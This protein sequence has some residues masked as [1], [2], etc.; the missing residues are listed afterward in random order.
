M[1]LITGTDRGSFKRSCSK[2]D[3]GAG[4]ETAREAPG[5]D[6]ASDL[7]DNVPAVNEDEIDGE[8]HPEGMH[9]LA[10]HD[11]K[12]FA[13]CE[14]L[15]TEEATCAGRSAIGYFDTCHEALCPQVANL[16]PRSRVSSPGLRIARQ[17][18]FPE[19]ARDIHGRWR[20]RPYGARLKEASI[21]RIQQ[22]GLSFRKS[23]TPNRWTPRA[24]IP[25]MPTAA[26]MQPQSRIPDRLCS[27]W[28]SC[29]L[30]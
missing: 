22:C 28:M 16:P 5:G 12:A 24:A 3:D 2:L 1:E 27:R 9:R 29:R 19:P 10:G 18:K 20:Y 7:S 6:A 13:L 17:I 21:C 11:P 30:R 15:L 26:R 8:L 25:R 23:H 4:P 14:G